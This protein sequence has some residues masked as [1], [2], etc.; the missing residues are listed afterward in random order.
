MKTTNQKISQAISKLALL[1]LI[2]F[3][4][5]CSDDDDDIDDNP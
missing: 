5:S 3:T 1:L 4:Y 2:L